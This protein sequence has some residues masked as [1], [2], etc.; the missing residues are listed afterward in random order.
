MCKYLSSVKRD[1]NKQLVLPFNTFY[2]ALP[3]VRH[4]VELIAPLVMCVED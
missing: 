4:A 1:F 3:A 2:L